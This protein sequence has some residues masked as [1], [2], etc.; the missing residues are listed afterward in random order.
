MTD[1]RKPRSR[2]VIVLLLALALLGAGVA[3]AWRFAGVAPMDAPARIASL[4]R[5]WRAPAAALVLQGNVEVRQVN[6]GFKVA[7]RI[8]KLA[9][10]E[11]DKVVAGQKLGLA[12]EGLFRGRSGAGAGAARP[13]GGQL[14]KMEAGNR[15]EE[16]AQAEATWPSARRRSTTRKSTLGSRASSCSRPPPARTR[17]TTTR[18]DAQRRRTRSSM[19]ARQALRLMKRGLPQGGHRRCARP[20]RTAGRRRQG[21]RAPTRRR[22][23]DRAERRRGQSRVREVGAIVNAGETVFVLSLTTPVWVRTYVSE[24][25]LAAHSARAWR[26]RCSPTAARSQADERAASASSPPTAEFT[27]KTVETRELRTA[28]VYRLRIVVDDPRRRS[29]A[30]HAD[31]RHCPR[32]RRRRETA[33]VADERRARRDRAPDQALRRRR[34]SPPSTP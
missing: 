34:T 8:K 33:A 1:A 31:D 20:A 21:R 16:I 17:P 24:P 14:A 6:L 13:G 12:G 26:S 3:A 25:D 10:D 29:A 32:R 18:V 19:S 15:P 9:V 4:W 11:G 5:Q 22:R 23:P 28:L 7:G 27:P 30:G 2:F